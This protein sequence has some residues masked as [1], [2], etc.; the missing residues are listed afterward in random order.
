MPEWGFTILCELSGAEEAGDPERL[1]GAFQGLIV[2]RQV[3]LGEGQ[4][5]VARAVGQA[6]VLLALGKES[7]RSVRRNESRKSLPSAERGC[8]FGP[9]MQS[10]NGQLKL[11]ALRGNRTIW[12]DFTG[13]I[14][15]P[16]EKIGRA[17]F[18][19]RFSD[20]HLAADG[21][22]FPFNCRDTHT[23]THTARVVFLRK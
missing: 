15:G 3:D 1:F 8:Y 17:R 22:F 13:S 12:T 20:F 5:Q 6:D 2:G 18:T 4:L 21:T 7:A 14:L 23:D 10:H 16:Q 9:F 19:E 11:L